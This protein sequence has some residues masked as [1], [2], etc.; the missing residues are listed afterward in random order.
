MIQLFT[1]SLLL[2]FSKYTT[3]G[4]TAQPTLG[5]ATTEKVQD[6]IEKNS[7]PPATSAAQF[8][9]AVNGLPFP[10][11]SDAEPA[12]GVP[13][14]SFRALQATP[15]LS[16]GKEDDEFL[17]IDEEDEFLVVDIDLEDPGVCQL[18]REQQIGIF[19]KTIERT[20]S[21]QDEPINFSTL[22]AFQERIEK[23]IGVDYVKDVFSVITSLDL[24]SSTITHQKF[25]EISLNCVNLKQLDLSDCSWVTDE[26]L[27]HVARLTYLEKFDLSEC[28]E[29]TDQGLQHIAGLA[30]LRGLD[31]LNCSKITSNG[32]RHIAR[33]PTLQWLNLRGCSLVTD[34]GLRHIARLPSLQQLNLFAC[35]KIT[36]EGLRYVAGLQN[37]ESKGEAFC[38][39]G[40][41]QRQVRVLQGLQHRSHRL[42]R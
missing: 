23:S 1:T 13:I 42:K 6:Y 30:N 20:A 28:L 7:I 18:S 12:A 5:V 27:Q 17:M 9:T 40:F 38:G 34:E 22:S 4:S 32:L 35:S 41:L 19:Q 26:G 33:L 24:S 39:G 8:V 10:I 14:V 21:M 25:H 29:I 16:E 15:S 31:L 37:R 36:D 3:D 2:E 11:P